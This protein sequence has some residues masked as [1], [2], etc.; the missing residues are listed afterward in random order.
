MG[1]QFMNNYRG[2]AILM[3]MLAHSISTV[4]SIKPLETNI[5]S[6]VDLHM[7]NC[8]LLFVAVAGYFFS[9]LSSNY[10]YLPFL[11]NKFKAVVCPYFFISIPMITLYIFNFKHNHR[12]I[13][14]NWFHES[15]DPLSQY[16]LLMLTGAHLGPL[17]FVP[18]IIIF[19]VVSPIFI[20][21]QNNRS[22]LV[23]FIFSLG[24]AVY[25]G[26]PG[27]NENTFHSFAYFLPAFF[28]GMLL[29]EKKNW[30]ECISKYSDLLLL[31]YV[32]LV[33]AIYLNIEV[34]SSIDLFIK[35]T[36]AFL[37]FAFLFKRLNYKV[38]WLDLFA[39][40]SFYL[41]FIHGYFTGLAR[42]IFRKS[43][44]EVEEVSA[45]ILVFIYIVF[46]SLSSYV[47]CKLILKDKTKIILGA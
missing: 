39:R 26:R 30:Y 2:I 29:S 19:Y 6:L 7:D 13:D 31:S 4:K 37:M 20:F 28:L 46:M 24:I 21:I 32:V 36:L 42:M 34:N 47:V 35:L 8:T 1:F 14:L 12:W 33:S 5:V 10:S 41:F 16:L 11:K 23:S 25:L 15:L 27:L 43:T 38:P 44:F 18:M 17:W 3:V 22:L 40:L 9:V 45:F